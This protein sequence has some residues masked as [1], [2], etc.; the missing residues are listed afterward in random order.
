MYHIE[1]VDFATRQAA[2]RA[3]RTAVFIEEQGVPKALE[4]DEH[5]ATA[6]HALA[7]AA[8]PAAASPIS[9]GV[10]H[11]ASHPTSASTPR[12]HASNDPDA[13]ADAPPP[14]PIGTGRLLTDGH[15]GRMAVLPAWR[16]QGVGRALLNALL[17]CARA[18]G[19]CEVVLSAQTQALGFYE[20]A[21]FRAEGPTYLDAG[22][23]HQRMSRQ[24]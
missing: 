22:I 19:M 21:G 3:I 10:S 23:L 24:L 20:R 18:Q 13:P 2:L 8:P 11:V 7:L 17:D 1:L 12:P 15:I 4:W 16:G 9:H 6:V 5:D 14:L